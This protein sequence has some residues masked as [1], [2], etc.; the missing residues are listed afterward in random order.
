MIDLL[1]EHGQEFFQVKERLG[2]SDVHVHA[3]SVCVAH[4]LGLV[5]PSGVKDEHVA[6]FHD[7]L[8]YRKWNN[9]KSS[10][11]IHA[12]KYKAEDYG[13]QFCRKFN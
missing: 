5:K 9:A 2:L 13:R 12:N 3:Q 7:T 11:H 10:T 4:L 6:C 8:K 1:R